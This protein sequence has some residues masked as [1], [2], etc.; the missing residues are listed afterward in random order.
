M[1]IRAASKL[2]AAGTAPME[3]HERGQSSE[4]I[5]RLGRNLPLILFPKHPRGDVCHRERVHEH[6]ANAPHYALRFVK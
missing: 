5:V 4:E 6:G 2:P 3:C 1:A